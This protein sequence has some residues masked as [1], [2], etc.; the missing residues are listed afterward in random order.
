MSI[1]NHIE[2]AGRPLKVVARALTED[3][4]DL[5]VGKQYDVI[6]YWD[7]E[8]GPTFGHC[9]TIKGENGIMKDCLEFNDFEIQGG[10]WIVTER[11]PE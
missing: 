8:S 3:A 4:S 11:A 2:G 1:F 9:F 7:S 10:N 5:K 6:S